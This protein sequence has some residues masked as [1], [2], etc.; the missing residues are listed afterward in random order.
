MC[1]VVNY[2]DRKLSI[3][4]IKT[5]FS[6][7]M[8]LSK[9][10]FKVG[11]EYERLPIDVETAQSVKYFGLNGIC[12]FLRLY[13]R[14]ENWD[15]LLDENNIIGL[16][17]L[18]NTV[19]LEPGLQLE[20]S[21]EPQKKIQTLEAKIN[22]LDSE[23]IP[24]L[25][26]AGIKLLAYGIYPNTT[27]K[28]IKLLPKRRYS[29]MASYLWGILSDVMMR[30]TAG[31]Q[32]CFDYESEEDAMK[33]FKVA[34]MLTPIVTGMFANS[35]I[36]GGV[37]TGYKSF[38]AL[39]WLNTDNDR[40]GFATNFNS[41]NTFEDYINKVLD[42]P[43]IMINREDNVIP[44]SKRITMKDFIKEGYNGF[45]ACLDDFRLASNLYFPEVRLREFIEIRNHD[46]IGK[47]LQYSLLAFYKGILY[48]PKILSDAEKILSKFSA[49]DFA[50]L[51]YNVPK[52]AM[53]AKL[54]EY[55]IK[56]FAKILV[57]LAEQGLVEQ[58][59]GEEKYL[60]P[61]KELVEEGICPADIILKNWYGAWN[62]DVN[63]L[64]EHVTCK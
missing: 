50:E 12:E 35:P 4:E 59:L 57:Q 64:I 3:N 11:F 7:G 15:Y 14:N 9:E 63:K 20:L 30:E 51:R 28:N 41:D 42:T 5:I 47:G 48:S 33:K 27:Y 29:I 18:H 34:N 2:L 46:S 26:D 23:M 16:K 55:K 37:D 17:Q 56:Q 52:L 22:E 36:R 58:N 31:M 40:C 43:M 62:K 25:N 45:V 21:I 19:T 44:I 32:A 10:D 24:L 61:L 60:D 1:I 6:A 53:N 13:A 54:G 38:R 39:A 8:K 49:R